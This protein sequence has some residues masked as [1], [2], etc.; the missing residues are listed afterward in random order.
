M[1]ITRQYIR[2]HPDT[3]FVFGDN[4]KRTGLGGQARVC[5]GEPNAMG[6]RVKK[7]PYMK[8]GSFYTD[9]EL[10]ANKCKICD[11]I[12]AIKWAVFVHKKKLF[13][14]DGIGTG[15]AELDKRAPK[16]FEYLQ[17]LLLDLK[18]NLQKRE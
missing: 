3:I 10:T 12:N 16:T 18:L 2:S 1:I 9:E 13:I 6:I 5:R 7:E 11:D 4:D 14:L 15:R 8:D 17:S